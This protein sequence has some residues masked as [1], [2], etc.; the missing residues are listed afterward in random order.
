M[1]A[2]LS[3]GSPRGA[4]YQNGLNDLWDFFLLEFL[5]NDKAGIGPSINS[6]TPHYLRSSLL[7][8]TKEDFE[9]HNKLYVF[10]LLI[11]LPSFILSLKNPDLFFKVESVFFLLIGSFLLIVSIYTEEELA[12]HNNILLWLKPLFSLLYLKSLITRKIIV[13]LFVCL[14]LFECVYQ[15]SIVYHHFYYYLTC[16]MLF[17]LNIVACVNQKTSR[18]G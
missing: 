4:F 1:W 14:L 7:K 8:S 9:N 5:L 18:Y 17:A 12:R 6:I 11:F 3:R 15:M 16:F 10:L 2:C 13:T